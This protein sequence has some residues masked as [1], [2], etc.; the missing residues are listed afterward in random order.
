MQGV[1]RAEEGEE[2]RRIKKC[3]MEGRT[4]EVVRDKGDL[5][6]SQ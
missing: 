2:V 3:D 5:C 6:S 4:V 1:G